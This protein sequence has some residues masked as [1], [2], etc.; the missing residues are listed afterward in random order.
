M[1]KILAISGSLRKDSFNTKIV[2][3]LQSLLGDKAKV[4]I[5]DISVLPFFSQDLESTFPSVAQAFKD[6]ILDADAI[7][8]ST[9]E[10]NRSMPGGLKNAIDWAS[11]PYGQNAFAGKPVLVLGAGGTVGTALAQSHLKEVLLYLDTKLIGQPEI[12]LSMYTAKYDEAAKTFDEK[13]TSLIKVGLD[14]L[15]TM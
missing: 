3:T 12:Y 14:K 4:T 10:Y 2:N 7:V 1:K 13:T 9:P 5:A 6:Q 8:I 11:R 15:M